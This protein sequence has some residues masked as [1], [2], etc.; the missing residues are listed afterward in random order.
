MR[1]VCRIKA[2]EICAELSRRFDALEALIGPSFDRRDFY[3]AGG[4]IYSLWNNKKPKDFDIFC[5]NKRAIRALQK[6]FRRHKEAADII[7]GN[8]ISMGEYQF[9]TRHIG[10]PHE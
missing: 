3:F 8:A 5:K 6:W 1:G 7:T 10:P 4:C 9:V 2:S